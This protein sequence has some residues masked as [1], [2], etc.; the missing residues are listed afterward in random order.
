MPR[1]PQRFG[2]RR[3]SRSDQIASLRPAPIVVALAIGVRAGWDLL[4]RLH[5]EAATRGIP[6]VVTSTDPRFLQRA[7][8]EAARYGSHRCLAKPFDVD[9]FLTLVDELIGPA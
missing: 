7:E 3:G 2:A 6:V 8:A 5:A 4:E 1:S 9:A